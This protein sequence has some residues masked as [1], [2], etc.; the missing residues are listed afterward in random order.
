MRSNFAVWCIRVKISA[1]VEAWRTEGNNSR[2]GLSLSAH[3]KK[4]LHFWLGGGILA[5]L[6]NGPMQEFGYIR[7]SYLNDR[8]MLKVV[9]VK[10][11]IKIIYTNLTAASK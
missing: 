6:Q 10:R 3:V 4:L 8:E 9:G 11:K 7:P 1:H 5:V 2:R